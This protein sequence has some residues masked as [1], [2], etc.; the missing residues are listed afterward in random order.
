MRCDDRDHPA[1][2]TGVRALDGVSVDLPAVR[3]TAITAPSGS[4]VAPTAGALAG[5]RPVRRA[6]RPD[7]LR[8]MAT[9]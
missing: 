4:L 3:F 7:V 1:H 9:G 6:A 2:G 5:L 8:A